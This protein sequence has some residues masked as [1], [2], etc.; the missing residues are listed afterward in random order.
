M[1][2]KHT[3]LLPGVSY[4]HALA[5]GIAARVNPERNT[6][7]TI[8]A[9]EAEGRNLARFIQQAVLPLLKS[10]AQC[11]ERAAF[12]REVARLE[13]LA[14]AEHDVADFPVEADRFATLAANF[15]ESARR[16]EE[17]VR[18]IET[19]LVRSKRAVSPEKAVASWFWTRQTGKGE[20]R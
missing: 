12:E 3:E 4:A 14:N 2:D 10:D 16:T 20:A 13:R 15:D 6:P 17:A 1:T 9:A 18:R 8:R 5:D 7:L 11:A 19:M